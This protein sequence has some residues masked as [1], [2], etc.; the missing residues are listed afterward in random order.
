MHDNAAATSGKAPDTP[1]TNTTYSVL[2]ERLPR[3]PPDK[4]TDEQRKVVANLT[5]SR[6]S[7]RGPFS[8][9]MRCP[10]LMDRMQ[11][12]GEC[13]RFRSG[14]PLRLS[15]LTSLMVARYWTNQYEW[16]TG[17]PHAR[18]AGL[19][20]DIIAPLPWQIRPHV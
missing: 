11:K 8:A 12:L 2:S 5:A 20:A 9:S 14:I 17:V 19:D 13:V 7:L 16:H 3:I 18:E 10:E 1:V 4:M 15:R 6:G